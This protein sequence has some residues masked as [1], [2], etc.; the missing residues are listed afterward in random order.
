MSIRDDVIVRDKAWRELLAMAH[1]LD[2]AHVKVGV[3]ASQGGTAT[4]ATVGPG[5]PITMVE[6]AAIHEFGSPAAGIVER[7]F[8]RSTIARKE[9]ELS[10]VCAKL[11]R[12]VVT[13]KMPVKKALG[14]LGQWV[15][16][17]IKATIVE[18]KTEGPEA[19]ENFLST[20]L[21]KG[22]DTPLVDTGRMINAITY[23]VF[24]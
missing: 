17:Q 11:A 12:G 1:G 8:I 15:T 6:L 14:I 5:T 21:R 16:A 10:D 20:V 24:E 18:R 9:Q 19:Q 22:S 4:A 23:E 13:Q 3:L 7:S 2:K